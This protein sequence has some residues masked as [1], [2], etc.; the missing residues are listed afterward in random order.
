M[1]GELCFTHQNWFIY[2]VISE[3]NLCSIVDLLATN[4]STI[5]VLVFCNLGS[6][7][8]EGGTYISFFVLL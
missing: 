3:K 6:Q 2:S 4:L 1:G 7:I 5:L 8:Q